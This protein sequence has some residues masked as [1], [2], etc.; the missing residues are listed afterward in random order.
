MIPLALTIMQALV[1]VTT[2]I[3]YATGYVL[4]LL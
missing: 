3:G 4:G 2:A 1:V